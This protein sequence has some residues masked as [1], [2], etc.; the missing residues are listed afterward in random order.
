[1]FEFSLKTTYR[2]NVHLAQPT[3]L[4]AVMASKYSVCSIHGTDCAPSNSFP[5]S[6][7]RVGLR[8][9]DSWH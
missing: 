9:N 5:S 1:M 6:L 2:Q 4:H 3:I 8:N 7:I